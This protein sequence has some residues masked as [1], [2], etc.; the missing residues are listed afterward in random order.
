MHSPQRPELKYLRFENS[1]LPSKAHVVSS[2]RQGAPWHKN[3]STLLSMS[4]GARSLS[5]WNSAGKEKPKL[6]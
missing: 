1:A 6:R 4:I 3:E 5:Q 2:V